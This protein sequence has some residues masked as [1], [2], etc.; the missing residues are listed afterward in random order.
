MV[1]AE[2]VL[3]KFHPKTSEPVFSTVFPY[4]FRPEADN[5][6]ISGVTVDNVGIDVCVKFW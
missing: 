2:I 5:D 6:V 3:T 4:N 1:L